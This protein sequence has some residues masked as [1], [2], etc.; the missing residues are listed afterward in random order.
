MLQFIL[1]LVAGVAG[2][3]VGKSSAEAEA[4]EK[5]DAIKEL[6]GLT[7]A[8]AQAVDALKAQPIEE[9]RT[10]RTLGIGPLSPL[11]ENASQRAQE[12]RNARIASGQVKP[13]VTPAEQAAVVN[14]AD[15]EAA[16]KALVDRKVAELVL[17]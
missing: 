14:A 4:S 8:Q 17:H 13:I 3:Q 9:V 5:M 1:P 10:R 11:P 15:P 12:I 6:V 2:Q 7:P 16:M